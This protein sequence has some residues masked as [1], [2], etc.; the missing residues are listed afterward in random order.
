M[1]F[2]NFIGYLIPPA[3]IRISGLFTAYR[4]PGCCDRFFFLYMVVIGGYRQAD[5][6]KDYSFLV[7]LFDPPFGNGNF[8]GYRGFWLSLSSLKMANSSSLSASSCFSLS[9]S[10][11][12][13]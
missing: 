11:L 13:S 3:I 2:D 10:L 4:L 8:V 9:F 5:K 6:V 1:F 7:S 12:T